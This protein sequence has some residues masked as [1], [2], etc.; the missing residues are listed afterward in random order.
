MISVA[1][2]KLKIFTLFFF[3]FLESL[4]KTMKVE[5]STLALDL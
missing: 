1:N 4:M 2:V 5:Y 3:F